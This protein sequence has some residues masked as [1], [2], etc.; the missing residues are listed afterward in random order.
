MDELHLCSLVI[1]LPVPDLLNGVHTLAQ[2]QQFDLSSRQP[3]LFLSTILPSNHWKW[4][5]DAF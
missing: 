2:S 5:H 1:L 4:L 3:S